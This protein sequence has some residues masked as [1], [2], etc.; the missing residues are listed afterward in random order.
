M[1]QYSTLDHDRNPMPPGSYIGLEPDVPQSPASRSPQGSASTT[2]AAANAPFGAAPASP[3]ALRFPG[4]DGGCSL[5]DMAQR[6]LDAALQL[7]A[8]RAQYMTEAG[9]AEMALRRGAHAER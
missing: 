2:I 6:D 7:L 4:E 8:E 9:G 3:Q 5:A 1:D